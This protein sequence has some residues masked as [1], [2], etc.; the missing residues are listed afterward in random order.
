MLRTVGCHVFSVEAF[1][2]P[3]GGA[4][5]RPDSGIN[6]IARNKGSTIRNQILQFTL[7]TH[8][9]RRYTS[10]HVSR[11]S[12]GEACFRKTRHKKVKVLEVLVVHHKFAFTPGEAFMTLVAMSMPAR[13]WASTV[14]APMWG[15]PWKCSIW[16]SG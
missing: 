10:T 6:S 4:E 8:S 5:P 13:P 1:L 9:P 7:N 14:E 11:E 2:Q 3:H 16:S 12:E 15:V